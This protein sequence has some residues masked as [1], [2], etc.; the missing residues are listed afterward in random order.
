MSRL[1][2]DHVAVAVPS[3][4]DAATV[5]ERL[6]GASCSPVQTVG[7]QGVRVAFVGPVELLEPVDPEG[8]V[9]RFLERRGP[10]LHHIAYRTPDI[11]REV[12]R[13][14]SAGLVFVDPQPRQGAHGQV[15]FIHPKS[16]GGVLVELVQRDAPV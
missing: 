6:T 14:G 13:L 15:A 12:E 9:A 2:F 10:G 4:R 1:V 5:L 11:R 16:T 7:S 8:P 3:I